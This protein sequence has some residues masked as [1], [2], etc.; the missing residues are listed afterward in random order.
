M[1]FKVGDWI[2]FCGDRTD[3]NLIKGTHEVLNPDLCGLVVD[4]S[5]DYA[6]YF[7]EVEECVRFNV[8]I[9]FHSCRN[10]LDSQRGLFIYYKYKNDPYFGEDNWELCDSPFFWKL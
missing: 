9:R 5:D 2:R 7:P 10:V 1:K 3:S 8:Y 6:V 4:D